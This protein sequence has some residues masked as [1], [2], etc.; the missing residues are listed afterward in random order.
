[1]ML[2]RLLRE[3][4]R[5]FAYFVSYLVPSCTASYHM[6]KEQGCDRGNVPVK[7]RMHIAEGIHEGHELGGGEEGGKGRRSLKL[8]PYEKD[9]T[10]ARNIKTATPNS[11]G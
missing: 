10:C 9:E 5:G 1:M 4:E 2:F 7:G 8:C 6:L 3:R 11:S